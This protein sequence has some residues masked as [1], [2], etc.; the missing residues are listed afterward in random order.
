M[1]FT[2][3]YPGN[4]YDCD[5]PI[6]VGDLIEYNEAREV[7]H[8]LCPEES[9]SLGDGFKRAPKPVCPRCFLVMVGDGSGGYRCGAC[10]D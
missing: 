7:R 8:V 4:C 1:A 5:D 9:T 6:V 2:A 3:R 10:D